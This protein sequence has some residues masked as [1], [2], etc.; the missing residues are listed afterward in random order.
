MNLAR[1]TGVGISRASA[2]NAAA[3]GVGDYL[4]FAGDPETAV[5]LAYLETV[6]RRGADGARDVAARKPLV[7]LK[8]GATLGGRGGGQPH[9][10]AGRRRQII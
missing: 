2:G 3:V 5:G 1:S 7:L 4:D 8:G 10:R 6:R 9:R